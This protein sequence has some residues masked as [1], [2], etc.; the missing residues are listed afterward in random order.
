MEKIRMLNHKINTAFH[1]NNMYLKERISKTLLKLLLYLVAGG[2]FV[3]YISFPYSNFIFYTFVLYKFIYSKHIVFWTAFLFIMANNPWGL[4]Y[5]RPYDWYI[6]LTSTVGISYMTAIG[7]AF[8]LKFLRMKSGIKVSRFDYLKRFYKPFL[9]YVFFLLLWSIPYGHN[10]QSVFK[11]IKFIPSF[12]IFLLAPVLLNRAQV[13]SFNKLIFAFSLIHFLGSVVEIATSNGFIILLTF[14]KPPTGVSGGEELVRITGGIILHLYVIIA[15]LYYLANKQQAFKKWYLWLIVL[16]SLLFV[17]SSATRGWMIA[18]S[19]LFIFYFVYSFL[20]KGSSFVNL[21]YAIIFFGFISLI[22]PDSF[23]KNMQSAF[24]R[25][26][27]IEYLI[28]GDITAGGTLKRLDVRGPRV[29][30][31]FSESP[32]VGFGYSKVTQEYYDGHVGNHS[33]LLM[34]GVVGLAI[35]WFTAIAIMLYFFKIDLNNPGHGYFV[36]ALA[37][38]AIMIIHSSSRIMVSYYFPANVA[39]LLGLI[40]NNFNVSVNRL[41]SHYEHR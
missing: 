31:K 35:V 9:A 26:E 23:Q 2:F 29:M 13:F 41:N 20:L 11:L 8:Y 3:Y 22:L 30:S 18:T 14:G 6:E 37:I 39:F 27:T 16:F 36:F 12:F 15:G 33:L 10:L 25:L 5:Y 24:N 7:V 4:F 38:I 21:L 1:T 32:I 19:V 34:G 40:F 17:F 28:E